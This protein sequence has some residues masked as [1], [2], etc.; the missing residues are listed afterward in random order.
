MSVLKQQ[1]RLV[2]YTRENLL[3]FCEQLAT[4]DYT[5]ELNG[6]GWGSIRTLHVHVADCYQ[7]WLA[8]FALKKDR[9]RVKPETIQNVA[10]MREQ[11]SLVDQ[12]VDEF[13]DSYHKDFSQQITGFVPW[14]AGEERLSVLWLF[15][16][17]I[18]HEFHHKG[19]IVTMARQLGYTPVDTDLLTPTDMEKY[20]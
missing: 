17:T 3:S 19:Q 7:A 8:H 14:Q 13:L 6:F 16:H 5:R 10:E 12:L 11:F 9:D 18:T 1:Y 20:L 2:R 4:E 15:T